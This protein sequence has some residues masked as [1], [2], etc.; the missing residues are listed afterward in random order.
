MTAHTKLKLHLERHMYKRGRYKGE[1]PADSSRRGK[2]H[3][4]V[5]EIANGVMTVRMHFTNLIETYQDGR[6]II[7]TNGWHDS[8]TTRNNLNAALREFVGFGVLGSRKHFGMSQVVINVRGKTYRYYDG[9]EFNAE[10]ELLTKPI[11][12]SSKRTDREETAAFRAEIA[13]S[14]FK[15][16]FPVL[17]AAAQTSDV[18]RTWLRYPMARVVTSAYHSNE[19]P[20]A[21]ALIKYPT[22]GYR[23]ANKAA[24]P[25]HKAAYKALVAQCT[26]TMTKIEDTDVTIL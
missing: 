6:V 9:M 12:F 17:Y 21:V 18:T 5:C 14:G 25:D 20:L 26:K 13:Q 10:G 15:D 22:L 3:F 2:T 8:P 7:N 23:M 11:A 16:V 24:Y 1:A 4:R 19:W